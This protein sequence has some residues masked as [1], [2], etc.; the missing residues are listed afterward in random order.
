MCAHTY[1]ERRGSDQSVWGFFKVHIRNISLDFPDYRFHGKKKSVGVRFTFAA[2]SVISSNY[3]LKEQQDP[4]TQGISMISSMHERET[5]VRGKSRFRGASVQACPCRTR[6]LNVMLESNR[7]TKKLQSTYVT[8]ST[9]RRKKYT[10]HL[11][12]T[13]T[14][15]HTQT[16][17]CH[18]TQ[19]AEY[20]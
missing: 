3:K 7:S 16:E 5:A 19:R 12:N 14:H 17:G 15:I 18:I 9:E 20:F 4:D 6:R 10:L 11:E 1:T 8:Q 13:R 2:F